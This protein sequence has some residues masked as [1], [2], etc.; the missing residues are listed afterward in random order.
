MHMKYNIHINQ[1]ALAHTQLD[2]V[3]GAILDWLVAFCNSKSPQIEKQRDENGYTWVSLSSIIKDMPLLRINT[4]GAISR[5][6][7]KIMEAGFVETY[8]KG[9][10]RLY[11][12]LTALVDTLFFDNLTVAVKQQGVAQKQR[13]VAVKQPTIILDTNTKTLDDS[14]SKTF[15][16]KPT[17]PETTVEPVSQDFEYPALFLEFWAV[18][19]RKIG[20]F[21]AY[22][23]WSKI[24][25]RIN[26][27]MCEVITA[28]VQLHAQTKQWQ[29]DD[30]RY[31]PHAST[32][33]KEKRWQ[34][35][36]N[37]KPKPSQDSKY[38]NVKVHK[39]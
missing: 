7:K 17:E 2:I 29:E 23:E 20:K 24:R 35:E 26:K 3:D 10:D 27:G 16:V 38:K 13:G 14:A 4:R 11:V 25:P 32:F 5:R 1:N 18:Y 31:I 15:E 22:L 6:I 39:A 34:D 28:S 36:I 30:G 12:R 37:E 21:K 33:I 19:P 8:I 9:N